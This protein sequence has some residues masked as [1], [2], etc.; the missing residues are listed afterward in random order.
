MYYSGQFNESRFYVLHQDFLRYVRNRFLKSST[1]DGENWA[2][3]RPT[4]GAFMLFLAMYTCDTVSAYG[5]MTENYSEYSNYYYD[6]G[7]KTKVIFYANHDYIMEMK[8]W[9]KLHD[10]NLIKF[11]QGNSTETETPTTPDTL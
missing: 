9:K 4:N 5:F 8:L 7:A 6:R 2:I 1:L 11:Y 10:L 3:V